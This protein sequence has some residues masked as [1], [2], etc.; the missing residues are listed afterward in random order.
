MGKVI[1]IHA[2]C[3]TEERF[4]SATAI[5]E[6]CSQA[7][8]NISYIAPFNQIEPSKLNS[9][10]KKWSALGVSGEVKR[11]V[12][13]KSSIQNSVDIWND[14]VKKINDP[15][16]EKEVWI[17]LGRTLSKSKFKKK[18]KNENDHKIALQASIILLQTHHTV[19]SV[20]AKLKVFCG[21]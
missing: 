13:N 17:L 6:V 21:K 3:S 1:F 7:I 14:I 2:K 16:F 18:L 10:D 9:W 20:G 12:I 5:Q 19:L 8:K 15:R 4:V 11:I